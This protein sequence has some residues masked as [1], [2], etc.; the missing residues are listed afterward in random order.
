MNRT[1]KRGLL[2]AVTLIVAWK[3]MSA[4]LFPSSSLHYKLSIDVD[5]NGTIRHG[6]GVIGVGFQSQG[7]LRIDAT[8]QWSVDFSG[9]A[10]PID[11]GAKSTLFVLLTGDPKRERPSGDYRT[12]ERYSPFD[13]GRDGLV[14]YFQFYVN[15][16]PNGLGA[17]SKI[18]AF[19][20]SRTSVELTPNALPML[21]RFRD[22]SDPKTVELVDPNHLDASFGPR[23]KIAR[24]MV[25][26]TDAPMTVGIEK[27]LGWLRG[28]YLEK[29]L[30]E[31]HGGAVDQVPPERRLTDGDFWRVAERQL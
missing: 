5:D 20:N 10:F 28:G 17:K 2:I 23:V 22:V 3:A 26:I 15:D 24:A 30:F 29:R 27:R 21:V 11:I 12:D 16:L 14:E 4:V 9:E 31:P 8:P 19:A 7:P 25:E 6:E 13:A 18:D 1:V